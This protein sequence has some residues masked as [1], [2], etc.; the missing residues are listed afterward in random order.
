MYM[1]GCNQKSTLSFCKMLQCF[2][3][4]LVSLSFQ[5]YCYDNS[6][7]CEMIVISCHNLIF[8]PTI[9]TLWTNLHILRRRE[10]HFLTIN[11][12]TRIMFSSFQN[13]KLQTKHINFTIVVSPNISNS[14]TCVQLFGLSLRRYCTKFDKLIISLSKTQNL[15]YQW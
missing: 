15:F 10:I 13:E 9:K 6:S 7:Q 3:T 4:K 5:Q 1:Q 12:T 8:F 11:N 2:T 14:K